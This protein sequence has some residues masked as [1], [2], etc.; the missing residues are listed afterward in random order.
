MPPRVALFQGQWIISSRNCPLNAGNGSYP[1]DFWTGQAWS[2]DFRDAMRFDS[3]AAA[4][5]YL[6]ANLS[7]LQ[8]APSA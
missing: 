5:G 8:A 3:D 6:A 7:R 4:Q 2:A 1:L